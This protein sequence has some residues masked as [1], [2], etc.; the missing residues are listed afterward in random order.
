MALLDRA[1]GGKK[2]RYS[3]SNVAEL[4]TKSNIICLALLKVVTALMIH[5]RKHFNFLLNV[6]LIRVKL[7]RRT[8]CLI[9]AWVDSMGYV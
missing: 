1:M 2:L 7:G 5:K 8:L 6:Q 9:Y 4:L 3:D